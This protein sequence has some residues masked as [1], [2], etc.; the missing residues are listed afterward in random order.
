VSRRQT[1]EARA[2]TV[3]D[4]NP[5]A[6][7]EVEAGREVDIVLAATPR[8]EVPSVVG[9]S[10]ED[11]IAALED[12]RL[13]VGQQLGQND[14]TI[15]EGQVISQDPG[16]GVP[17]DIGTPVDLVYSEGPSVVIVPDVLCRT[18]ANAK[19]E[20]EGLGLVVV[21]EDPVLPR[22]ECPNP[23]NVAQQDTP[24]GSQV[25]PGTTIVLHQGATPSPSPSPSPTESPT[26]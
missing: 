22:P 9:L 7:N 15:P 5:R 21:L 4:Q 25:Q 13:E 11:A 18:Y 10:L 24:S 23:V 19:A 20:L 14:P 3:I 16:V 1:D 6:G 2:G 12:A 26:P 17:V 8:V